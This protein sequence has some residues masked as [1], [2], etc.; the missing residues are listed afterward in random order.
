MTDDI[1][2]EKVSDDMDVVIINIP[3]Q[4]PCPACNTSDHGCAMWGN[5]DVIC[6]LE[7]RSQEKA[8]QDLKHANKTRED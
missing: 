5:G 8:V 6:E 2:V 4:K 7:L 1:K 3:T